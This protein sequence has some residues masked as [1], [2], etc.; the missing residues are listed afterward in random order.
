[1][2]KPPDLEALARRYVELWQDQIAATAADP[3]LTEGAGPHDADRRRRPRGPGRVVAS[4]MWPDLVRRAASP[5]PSP[6]APAAP[7]E[8]SVG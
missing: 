2:S 8:G 6:P 7:P 4:F 5:E 1:M 3:E